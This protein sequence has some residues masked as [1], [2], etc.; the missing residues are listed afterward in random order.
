MVRV[1]EVLDLGRHCDDDAALVAIRGYYGKDYDTRQLT[2]AT[3]GK[4]RI[5]CTDG[6]EILEIIGDAV[7][8]CRQDFTNPWQ[9]G[10]IFNKGH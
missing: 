6:G 1:F 2:F 9:R 4:G 10:S 5:Y 3:D 8:K 7:I